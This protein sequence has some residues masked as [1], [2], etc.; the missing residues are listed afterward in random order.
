MFFLSKQV[1]FLVGSLSADQTQ[2]TAVTAPKPGHYTTGEPP[3]F[4]LFELALFL[5]L[6]IQAY[7]VSS[8][9]TLLGK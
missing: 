8:S 9:G 5:G 3:S 2:A 6:D 7:Q 4:H 1:F